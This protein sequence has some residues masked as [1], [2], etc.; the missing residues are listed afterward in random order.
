MFLDIHIALN[1]RP[2]TYWEDDVQL[3]YLC[4][5]LMILGKANY[6]LELPSAEIEDGDTRKRAKYLKNCKEALWRRW[7]NEYMRALRES[8]DLRHNGKSGKLRGDVVLIKG[9]EKNRG[10]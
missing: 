8:H 1:N 10:T 7:R 4:S 6:L 9:E 2:L 5:R 3:Q